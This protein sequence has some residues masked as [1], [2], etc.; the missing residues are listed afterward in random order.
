MEPLTKNKREQEF[1]K[2]QKQFYEDLD[3]SVK[4]LVE[5]GD[6]YESPLAV[7]T[8]LFLLFWTAVE[9]EAD[10]FGSVKINKGFLK[11]MQKSVK[12]IMDGDKPKSIS[13]PT[14]DTVL[15]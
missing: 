4:D 5:L 14:S 2:I 1:F 9:N 7:Y 10:F 12:K 15:H 8:I 11:D 6:I 3:K 13:C